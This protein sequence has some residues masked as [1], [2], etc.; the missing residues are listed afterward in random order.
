MNSLTRFGR[1]FGAF[2]LTSYRTLARATIPTARRCLATKAND[3][4]TNKKEQ[5]VDEWKPLRD[6]PTVLGLRDPPVADRS[7]WL[8]RKT[9][10]IKNFTDYEKA[11]AAHAAERRHLVE[12]ATK[13][14][15]ADVH[16]MRKTQGK[17]YYASNK[18]TSAEKA[19]YMPD[20]EGFNVS[21]DTVHTTDLLLGKVSLMTFVYAKFGEAHVN[22]F[23]NPFLQKFGNTE[24][25]QVVELNVQENF[26]KQ[27]LLRAFVPSIRRNLPDARK[28]NYVFLMKDISRSRK[29]LDMT[30]QYIGYVFLVD[31][32]CKIRWT[33][34]GNAS[35]EEV[36][37]MLA[38][39]EYLNNKRIKAEKETQ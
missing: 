25:V 20:Y 28:P 32:N 3:D 30:N 16:E 23:I 15:F 4:S 21:K 29:M 8:Q 7:S 6:P 5:Q 9:Q 38:M 10:K 26:L 34:H 12:E 36:A 39:T 31:E 17:M 24:G 22:S 33:A 13:S 18:L 27:L 19:G 1:T 14:Y 35:A 11:F 2:Q 37:N